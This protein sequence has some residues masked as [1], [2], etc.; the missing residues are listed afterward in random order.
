MNEK[1]LN[2]ITFLRCLRVAQG[3]TRVM[4]YKQKR[5]IFEIRVSVVQ[6]AVGS[7]KNIV[8]HEPLTR[9]AST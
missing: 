6:L 8:R 9:E 3:C 5:K 4:I 1:H 7:K 2:D